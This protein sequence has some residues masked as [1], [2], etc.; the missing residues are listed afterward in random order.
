MLRRWQVGLLVW[1]DLAA[2]IKQY[3]RYRAHIAHRVQC[4]RDKE[5]HQD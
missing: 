1:L 2:I 5:R 3:D 4:G